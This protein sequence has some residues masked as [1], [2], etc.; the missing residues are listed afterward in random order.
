MGKHE[1][2]PKPSSFEQSF[3]HITR[4]VKTHGWVEIGQDEYSR[5]IVR[6][7]DAGG[8]VWEGQEQGQYATMDEMLQALESGL[9]ESMRKRWGES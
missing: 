3:P 2:K 7:L 6:A 4:W 5:S 1:D 9:A 8:M